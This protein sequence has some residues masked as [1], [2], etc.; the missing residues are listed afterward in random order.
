[1]RNI[2][3]AEAKIAR[4]PEFLLSFDFPCDLHMHLVQAQQGWWCSGMQREINFSEQI[5]AFME[6]RSSW[7]GEK[8]DFVLENFRAQNF[9]NQF[10]AGT[11]S[12][13][14]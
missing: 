10:P 6:F 13:L 9:V 4:L 14:Y 3:F 5:F 1:M 11:L 12:L 8:Y 7:G 2:N